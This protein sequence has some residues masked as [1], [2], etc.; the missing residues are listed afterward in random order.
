MPVLPRLA[1]RREGASLRRR[2]HAVGPSLWSPASC[3]HVPLHEAAD[4]TV[5]TPCP[6]RRAC[7]VRREA[8][9]GEFICAGW[10]LLLYFALLAFL[11]V[12]SVGERR[13]R[14]P[15]GGG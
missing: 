15:R 5:A 2:R 4:G 10:S 3:L 14:E 1:A 12:M 8:T 7:A 13:V 11:A 6:C 9:M